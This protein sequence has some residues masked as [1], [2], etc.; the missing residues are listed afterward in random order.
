M[1]KIF[2]S[3]LSLLFFSFY[4]YSQN[5]NQSQAIHIGAGEWKN[6]TAPDGSGIYF[7]IIKKIYP[8]YQLK[9]HTDTFNRVIDDFE[10]KKLDMVVGIYREDVSEAIFADWFLDTEYP[11]VAIYDP[12]RITVNSFD[13]LADLTLSWLRGYSFDRYLPQGIN[14]YEVTDIGTGFKL[15]EKE[16]IDAFVDF[17]YNLLP[18]ELKKYSTFE[19]LPARHIYV[20]FAHNKLG[21]KLAEQFDQKMIQLRNSGFLAQIYQQE[22]DHSQLAN[23]NPQKQK[24]IIYTDNIDAIGKVKK[25]QNTPLSN[26]S[27]A[28][29]LNNVLSQLDK[30]SIDFQVVKNFTKIE[31]KAKQENICFNHLLKTKNRLNY[32][33][34]S[35]PVSLS[36]GFK[37]YTTKALH[38]DE[39]VD[40]LDFFNKN[41]QYTIGF[42][43]GRSYGDKLDQALKKIKMNQKISQ[44]V[45]TQTLLKQLH[46]KRFDFVVEYPSTIQAYQHK[47]GKKK[48]YSYEIKSTPKHNIGY[49]MCANSKIG[50][51]FISDFNQALTWF[52]HTKIF[53][54]AQTNKVP[55][56]DKKG[57]I[58]LYKQTFQ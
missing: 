3:I 30:Y 47:F 36:F 11:I 54:N 44:S 33:V 48:L 2:V 9:F 20:A 31:S 6:Y 41:K 26:I 50:Q 35:K 46:S 21:K 34:A 43:S 40:L 42:E 55:L 13:G 29:V 22:Y 27:I 5:N 39:P 23:F 7:E 53:F 4:S 51:Q 19:V 58:E 16:R 49:T 32:L 8:N 15:L 14:Y 28:V 45:T 56:S 52:Y 1:Y 12:K 38:I 24:I 25:Y 57:F 10:Q 37:L 18:K 17:P